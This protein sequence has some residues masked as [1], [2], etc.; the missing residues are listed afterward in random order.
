MSTPPT[1]IS[2]WRIAKHSP[3]Y[4]AT[5]MDGAGG[6]YVGGRWHN[7][8]TPVIYAAGSVAL[9][10][11]ETLVHYDDSGLPFLRKLI[12]YRIPTELAQK[13][14][15]VVPPEGWDQMPDSP[16]AAEAGTRWLESKASLLLFVPSVIIRTESN[17]LINP[18]H[19]ELCGIEV[20]DHGRFNYDPR[21][22]GRTA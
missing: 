8:G 9:A 4:N 16:S 6:L 22:I 10:C 13:G 7:K 2:F 21:L 3:K 11:L 18:A 20:V 1:I 5:D 12:E 14:Q 15:N 19:P 17:V